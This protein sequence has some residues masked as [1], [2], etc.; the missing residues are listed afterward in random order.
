[1]NRLLVRLL[2]GAAILISTTHGRALAAVTPAITPVLMRATDASELE[3]FAAKEVRRYLYLR[4]GRLL[5]LKVNGNVRGAWSGVVL[6][7]RKD[8]ALAAGL[9]LSD[10]SRAVL[11][12]L[13]PQEFWL[14][15]V[16]AGSRPLL[17]LAGGDDPGTLHAA[18]R[19]A[20]VLGVRFYLHGDVLPDEP[21]EL[22]LP[23]FDE[24]STPL[25]AL[26]GLQPF[27]DFPEGPDWWNTDDYAAILA[28]MPKLRLNFLALH[29]YPEGGPCAE[30][31]VWIGPANEIGANGRVQHSYPASYMNT[32][33]GNWGYAPK[34]TGDY[35]FG[36]A[37]LFERDDFGAGVM[38]GEMPEPKTPEG[39]N[40]V[41]NRTGE[42][43]HDAFTLAHRLGVKTCVG[44]ET[45]L[46]VP[47][48][49]QARLRAAGK[50]PA[51]PA[52]RRELY[53]GLFQRAAAAYPLDY[54]WFWTPEGWTWEGTKDEQVKRTLDDLA[55]A[56]AAHDAV[57][58]PFALA[59]CGWVLGPQQ[60]RA[61][62]D[63]V[64]PPNVAVSCINRQVGNTP[65]DRG[66]SEVHGR[67]KWAI[68]WLE[69]DPG[70]TLPQ[71]WV[72]R[73]RRD[74][75]D[76]RRYG[77]DG[78]LGIHWRTRILA[79]NAAALAQA[80]W[81]QDAWNPDA[82]A[83]IEAPRS[84]GAVGGAVAAF[85]NNA[86][87]GTDEAPVYQTVRYNLSAYHL[88]L[89]N[90][91]YTV[92][93][94]FCEPH[95]TAAGKRVFQVA[96]QGQRVLER[97][98]IFER[99]GQNRALDYTC[100]NVAVQN[101]WLEVD[102]TPIIEF[103]S[104]AGIVVQGGVTRKINCGGPA[105]RDYEADKLGGTAAE[106][107][108]PVADF[109]RDWAAHEFGMQVGVAAAD[110][111]AGQDGKLPRP[112]DWVDGPGGIRPDPRPW[113]EVKPQFAFVEQFAA[114]RPQVRGAGNLARFDYWLANFR[115]LRAMA[116][117]NCTWARFNTAL[118]AAKAAANP[119]A[120]RQAARET[121][122]PVRRE[123]VRQTGEVFNQLF[124]TVSTTGELGTVM[125]WEQHNLPGLLTQPGAELAKLLGEPLPADA[126]P[127]TAYHGPTR[128]IVP[129]TRT[130]VSA[131]EP[132]HLKVIVL[133]EKPPRGGALHWRPLGE[134]AFAVLPLQHV[135]RGVYAV[136]LP[137]WAT[138]ADFE[139][140]VEVA[141][142][143]GNL[144]RFPAT[145]PTLNQ[146]VV[147][148][149]VAQS[150]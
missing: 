4:T 124:A 111:F 127:A 74:A 49:V 72:G 13:G 18:Y 62:F 133:A 116:E 43:L 110:V 91:H 129:T 141:D 82:V 70:L 27:H 98:D 147:T 109:Y 47:R 24:K 2:L 73:M 21:A 77:C 23:V 11:A 35:A 139:Y 25:F 117:V 87:A 38:F 61:L 76:A 81:Q 9:P 20:E 97:L 130:S 125:N 118:A 42:M 16:R 56:F 59:T 88:R 51:E 48:A 53:A 67:G 93:L 68:P 7:A 149:P 69:D 83:P 113:N 50:N 120:Q 126:Q 146:T 103:P 54:Y 148:L 86:I 19:F 60:D 31:T 128:V 55:A 17:L 64:L 1:M 115:Y 114:L 46:T 95:Y 84:D 39:A 105:Y 26:R 100:T 145:A 122:L 37:D 8:H 132:L 36:G 92:T 12:R 85:P 112:A 135:A 121:V 71:L 63:K 106:A 10:E 22:K 29:T 14:K 6:V 32:L 80:A 3:S 150:L 143:G 107:F 138:N 90:G 30:P 40:A 75:A 28:Q 58:A 99:V 44:T 41:F 119:D 137:S 101:G 52:V 94:K 144:T 66:F 136:E 34:K 108:P 78:L 142:A 96:L 140:Y 102:F 15:T 134:G 65:V 33:R 89:P 5:P 131:G 123:L 45:P 79:P 57:K 104:I